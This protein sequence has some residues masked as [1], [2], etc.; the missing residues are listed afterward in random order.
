VLRLS[1]HSFCEKEPKQMEGGG[2]ASYGKTGKKTSRERSTQ[3]PAGKRKKIGVDTRRSGKN[4]IERS[5]HRGG[6]RLKRRRAPQDG[7]DEVSGGGILAVRERLH[8]E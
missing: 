1:K 6:R 4:A 2:E 8:S 7:T 3:T 5:S